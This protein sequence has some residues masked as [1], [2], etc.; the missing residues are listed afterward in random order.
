M[1]D[2][3]QRSSRVIDASTIGYFIVVH[4]EGVR[5][6]SR[7]LTALAKYLTVTKRPQFTYLYYNMI[8]LYF[9]PRLSDHHEIDCFDLVSGLASEASL[10]ICTHRN[11]D[12]GDAGS[13]AGGEGQPFEGFVVRCRVVQVDSRTTACTYLID[14]FNTIV[15]TVIKDY[16]SRSAAPVT[17]EDLDT[18]STS[19]IH[20]KMELIGRPWSGVSKSAKSGLL[21]RG[22]PVV[23]R[24][25]ETSASVRPHVGLSAT[26]VAFSFRNMEVALD[27]LFA[28]RVL[29][30]TRIPPAA[31][32]EAVKPPQSVRA[33]DGRTVPRAPKASIS[34]KR[35]RRDLG[36]G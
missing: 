25:D 31:P 30:E 14:A 34:E 27:A 23:A 15:K 19:E 21:I 13:K 5:L 9:E 10:Y 17:Q 36:I 28:P 3:E 16:T 22:V 33:G 11:D 2:L 18:L 29:Q 6:H 32:R 7:T 1:R 35:S 12:S 24:G 20:E 26:R 4:Y 8:Y